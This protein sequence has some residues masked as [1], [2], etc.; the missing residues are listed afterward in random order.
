MNYL[1][2]K[3]SL[4]ENQFGFRKVYSTYMAIMN[5]C[6]KISEAIDQN[7]FS[8]G[9]FL[10]LSKAFD[11]IHHDISFEKLSHY[12]VRSSALDWFKSYFSNRK[13]YIFYNETSS[14]LCG[15][16]DGV[17]QGSILGRLL[18]ILYIND[19]ANSSNIQHFVIFADD[20]NLF[21]TCDNIFELL[22]TANCELSKLV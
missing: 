7:K 2:S 22:T 15:V 4:S 9:I 5:M 19:L 6:N 12:G 20:I 21:H 18:F 14:K 3:N 16:S 10:N 11:T 8:I 17:P 1:N 13:Q